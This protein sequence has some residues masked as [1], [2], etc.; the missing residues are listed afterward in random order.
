[1]GVEEQADRRRAE[2]RRMKEEIGN[3]NLVF[4]GLG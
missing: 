2:V 4:M 1:M 3:V